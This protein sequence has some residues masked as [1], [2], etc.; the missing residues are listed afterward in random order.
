ASVNVVADYPIAVTK[1]A[2]NADAA[3]AFVNFV[4]STAGQ[5]ILKKWGFQTI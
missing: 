4:T 5:T 3:R 1:D 2:R